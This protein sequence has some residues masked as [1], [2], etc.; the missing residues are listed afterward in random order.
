[1]CADETNFRDRWDGGHVAAAMVFAVKPAIGQDGD[2]WFTQDVI[3]AANSILSSS[4]AQFLSGDGVNA[5]ER[6]S[7]RLANVNVGVGG[8][9]VSSPPIQSSRLEVM[10]NDPADDKIAAFDISTHSETATAAYGKQ[11]GGGLQRLH[12]V[13]FSRQCARLQRYGLCAFER[14]RRYLHGSGESSR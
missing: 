10:V 1:M 3:D 4:L 5:L 11:G 2:T 13:R 12:G 6:Q 8:G 7:E 9:R 14:W